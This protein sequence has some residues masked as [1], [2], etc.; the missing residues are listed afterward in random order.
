MCV[1][2]LN[3]TYLA[4]WWTKCG[5]HLP[6]NTVSQQKEVVFGGPKRTVISNTEVMLNN[7]VRFGCRE[8]FWVMH[9]YMMLCGWWIPTTPCC[10]L[11]PITNHK[12]PCMDNSKTL[13][14]YLASLCNL[15]NPVGSWWDNNTGLYQRHYCGFNCQLC[16]SYMCKPA[17]MVIRNNSHRQHWSQ[18]VYSLLR[19]TRVC[20][21]LGFNSILLARQA[22]VK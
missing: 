2:P 11:H 19:L 15:Y 10:K 22:T 13:K 7:R 20:S 6:H 3:V 5:A 1:F 12:I 14:P 17:A 8:C 16:F 21:L 9:E 4:L 18:G